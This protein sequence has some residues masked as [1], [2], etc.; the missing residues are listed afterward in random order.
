MPT[1]PRTD[2]DRAHPGGH[3]VTV[4]A[5]RGRNNSAAASGSVTCSKTGPVTAVPVASLRLDDVPF[6]PTGNAHDLANPPATFAVNPEM[7]D[8]VATGG[9]GWYDEGSADVLPGEHVIRGVQAPAR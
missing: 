2:E 4:L 9:D 7:N 6:G 3:T 5:G 8:Q 1:W